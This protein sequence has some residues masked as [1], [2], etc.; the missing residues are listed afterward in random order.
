[1]K[2]N[3]RKAPKLCAWRTPRQDK[4]APLNPRGQLS[5]RIPL[6]SII[7]LSVI[8]NSPDRKSLRLCQPCSCSDACV[9]PRPPSSLYLSKY[10]DSIRAVQPDHLVLSSS[11]L[12]SKII[13]AY[14]F[15]TPMDAESAPSLAFGRVRTP[16]RNAIATN[17]LQ[18]PTFEEMR[19]E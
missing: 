17:S 18:V 13:Y 8:F 3:V 12:K 9:T 11:L 19:Q 4:N 10:C 14:L 5:G 6:N 7:S 1:M 2:S 15:A 16:F